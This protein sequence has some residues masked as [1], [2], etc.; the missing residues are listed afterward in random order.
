MRAEVVASNGVDLVTEL[1]AV[2]VPQGARAVSGGELTV[3]PQRL[4]PALPRRAGEPGV[5]R[6]AAA[7][8]AA[9]PAPTAAAAR[10]QQRLQAVPSRS[11][12]GR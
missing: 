1:A 2:L 5:G 6:R 12:S 4:T 7:R 11:G 10:L 9:Q 8:Q 3:D